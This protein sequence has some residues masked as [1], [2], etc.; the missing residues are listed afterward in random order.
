MPIRY[1]IVMD[2]PVRAK[3]GE[4]KGPKGCLRKSMQGSAPTLDLA[5]EEV[6]SILEA[7][8]YG[9]NVETRYYDAAAFPSDPLRVDVAVPIL[10]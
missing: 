2:Y 4:Q 6:A 8:D 9:S 10:A 1:V 3:R 7:F 5:V